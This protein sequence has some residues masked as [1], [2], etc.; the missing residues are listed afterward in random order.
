V[1]HPG[2]DTELHT[3]LGASGDLENLGLAGIGEGSL[4]ADN[5]ITIGERVVTNVLS[6]VG[7]EL[8]GV[9]G[10]STS[11]LADELPLLRRSTV[12]NV[13]VEE[14]V[15][16]SQLSQ[17]GESESGRLHCGVRIRLVSDPAA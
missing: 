11:E 16:L 15:G 12:D 14:V 13:D 6:G 3:D 4:V 5:I 17:S 8:D 1:L 2:T 9:E 10:S 7:R